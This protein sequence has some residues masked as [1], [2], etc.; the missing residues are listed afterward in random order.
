MIEKRTN[1]TVKWTS[2]RITTEYLYVTAK[3][4]CVQKTTNNTAPSLPTKF[5]VPGTLKE[6]YCR[7]EVV[8]APDLSCSRK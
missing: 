2:F 6:L 8:S 3:N 7:F 5:P 1:I 4:W